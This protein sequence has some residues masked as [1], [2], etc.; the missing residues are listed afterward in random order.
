MAHNVTMPVN[1]HQA[2]CGE[3]A[4]RRQREVAQKQQARH[5]KLQQA[6]QVLWRAVEADEAWQLRT[7]R[8]NK[9]PSHCISSSPTVAAAEDAL[10]HGFYDFAAERYA[11]ALRLPSLCRCVPLLDNLAV[12][13]LLAGRPGEC[14]SLSATCTRLDPLFL[15]AWLHQARALRALNRTVEGLSVLH[16]ALTLVPENTDVLRESL[17]LELQRRHE[18]LAPV[19]P[20]DESVVLGALGI[21]GIIAGDGLLQAFRSSAVRWHPDLWL[22]A[23]VE[24]RAKAREAL[25]L[26][27]QAYSTLN[28]P[29]CLQ[30]WQEQLHCWRRIHLPAHMRK[31]W[32]YKVSRKAEARE[33][34]GE[35]LQRLVPPFSPLSVPGAG[36]PAAGMADTTPALLL[37][38]FH[39]LLALPYL[40]AHWSWS[41]PQISPADEDTLVKLV[42]TWKSDF[43]FYEPVIARLHASHTKAPR[44]S[45][46][47]SPPD[48]PAIDHLSP[49]GTPAP[50]PH[51]PPQLFLPS[52][53]IQSA[54]SSPVV[55]LPSPTVCASPE[56]AASMKASP[57][58][59]IDCETGKATKDGSTRLTAVGSPGSQVLDILPNHSSGVPVEP[60]ATEQSIHHLAKSNALLEVD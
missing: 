36:S 22:D 26:C 17:L 37:K 5:N 13:H 42:G 47:P 50:P 45:V 25:L 32:V 56:I 43:F 6:Q 12:A 16:S 39:G 15:P 29:Q 19:G 52:I 55:S 33:Q 58:L 2:I 57:L 10:N 59:D 23:T 60:K 9:L 31:A 34:R 24:E 38:M 8:P 35:P 49:P 40:H 51:E 48:H 20:A 7:N 3:Q 18:V 1:F 44:N 27:W 41:L 4:R 54:A 28:D 14:A 53:E 46:V 21:A 30:D 11:E